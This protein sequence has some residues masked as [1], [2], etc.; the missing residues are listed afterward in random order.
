MSDNVDFTST[1]AKNES[2]TST[3]SSNNMSNKIAEEKKLDGPKPCPYCGKIIPNPNIMAKHLKENC[4]Q[5]Y[6]I[7]IC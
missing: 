5:T 4:N 2:F 6:D 3:E 7:K 1:S